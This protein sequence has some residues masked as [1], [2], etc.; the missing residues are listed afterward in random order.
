[1]V[2]K[3][4]IRMG[5]QGKALQ[6]VAGVQTLAGGRCHRLGRL[7]GALAVMFMPTRRFPV[8][9]GNQPNR[10]HNLDVGHHGSSHRSQPLRR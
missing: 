4:A 2:F 6:V 10:S 7:W 9:F 5:L 3:L 1:M 8:L